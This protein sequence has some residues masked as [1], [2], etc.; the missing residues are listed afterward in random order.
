MLFPLKIL[1][2]ELG[3]DEFSSIMNFLTAPVIQNSI[4][5][6]FYNEPKEWL[7]ESPKKSTARRGSKSRR[8]AVPALRN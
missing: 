3:Y 8:S 7:T 5:I 6:H 4:E 2:N 1:Y